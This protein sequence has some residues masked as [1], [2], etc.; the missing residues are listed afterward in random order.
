MSFLCRSDKQDIY[1]IGFDIGKR[2]SNKLIG[3]IHVGIYRP[4]HGLVR[5]FIG[6][7]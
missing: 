2:A 4:I 3:L 6:A 5:V 1:I 7:L